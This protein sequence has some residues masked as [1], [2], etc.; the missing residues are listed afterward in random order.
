MKNTFLKKIIIS[1]LSIGL[2]F[3]ST[4]NCFGKFA[5]VRKVYSFND[6]I[7]AGSGL[8][9]RFVK[10]LVYYAFI[11]LPVYGIAGL[12]DVIILNL[13]EFWTGSNPLAQGDFNEEGIYTKTMETP[14]GKIEMTYMDFGQKL[15]LSF[16]KNNKT[17]SIL[18]LKNEPGK[19]FE[20]K[21]GK[22]VEANVEAKKFGSQILLK[23]YLSEKQESNM[24]ID[25][26]SYQAVESEV[27]KNL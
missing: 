9:N 11:F 24:I 19:V 22:L 15:K 27:L 12:V 25:A 17:E 20:E 6:S 18:F 13:I 5:L 21:N 8:L 2:L 1:L 23:H 4:A 26:K 16:S 10:T 7:N 3:T 14:E